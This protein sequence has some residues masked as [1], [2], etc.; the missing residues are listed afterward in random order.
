MLL[1]VLCSEAVES[2]L[3]KLETSHKVRLSPTVEVLCAR[4]TAESQDR[5]WSEHSQRGTVF[6]PSVPTS[7]SWVSS[8]RLCLLLLVKCRPKLTYLM[9]WRTLTLS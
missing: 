3:V 2:N 8:K 5:Q 9:P 7:G 4:L 1:F 6:C